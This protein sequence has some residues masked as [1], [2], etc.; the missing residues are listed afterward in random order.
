MNW[1]VAPPLVPSPLVSMQV[2]VPSGTSQHVLYEHLVGVPVQAVPAGLLT[3]FLLAPVKPTVLYSFSQSKVCIAACTPFALM[4]AQV[5]VGARVQQ[6]TASQP[7]LSRDPAALEQ[8]P[9]TCKSANILC[10][11]PPALGMMTWQHMV[12]PAAGIFG[13]PLQSNAT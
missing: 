13:T 9:R 5:F 11:A 6:V 1:S 4:S 2:R 12:P 7:P 10:A 3:R 8:P